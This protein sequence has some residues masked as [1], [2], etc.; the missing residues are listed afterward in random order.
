MAKLY[1]KSGEVINFAYVYMDCQENICTST[2][3][4]IDKSVKELNYSVLVKNK[5]NEI[6]KTKTYVLKSANISNNVNTNSDLLNNLSK[7]EI[8]TEIPNPSKILGGFNDNIVV[9]A[10]KSSQKLATMAQTVSSTNITSLSTSAI[11]G[12]TAASV[13]TTTTVT[14]TSWR[15]NSSCCHIK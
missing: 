12:G 9:S 11:V 14:S 4:A 15:W 6:Y 10:V 3:P 13:S 5:N 8:K 1:F 2:I 7:I